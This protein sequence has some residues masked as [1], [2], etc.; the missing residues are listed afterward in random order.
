MDEQTGRE[1]V[2]KRIR[3]TRTDGAARII[4]T[5]LGI[6]FV[7]AGIMKL[8]VPML[9]EAFSGQLA[10]ANIPLLQFN[11]LAI[12]FIEIGVGAALLRGYYTRIAALLVMDI[13]VVAIF[14]HLA[15]DDPSLFPLQPSA[16]IIP[17][18]VLLLS[19]YILTRGGGTGSLDLK[20]SGTLHI[21][22]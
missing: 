21:S 9:A 8:V 7:M 14:V 16:P 2:W 4:R 11:E 19:L 5:A 10:A 17:I 20:E 18:V 1:M 15:A 12:P 3:T 6:M 22:T 13:M